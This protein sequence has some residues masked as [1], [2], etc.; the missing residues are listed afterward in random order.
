MVIATR[1]IR[2]IEML[3]FPELFVFMSF[4]ICGNPEIKNNTAGK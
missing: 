3:M 2:N 4:I 1:V